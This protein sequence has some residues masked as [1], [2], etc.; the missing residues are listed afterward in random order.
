VRFC[1]AGEDF[2][3]AILERLRIHRLPGA[4][5]R[6]IAAALLLLALAE[7]SRANEKIVIATEGAYPPFNWIDDSGQLR[8]F[9]V[10]IAHALCEQMRSTCE[11][12]TQKWDGILPGLVDKKY[13]AIVASMSNTKERR[14][15]VDF[16]IDYYRDSQSLVA[17]RG[18]NIDVTA[19]SLKDKTIGV[20]GPVLVI[21][22]EERHPVHE[23]YLVDKFDDVEVKIYDS[24]AE[25]VKDLGEGRIDAIFGNCIDLY[26]SVLAPDTGKRFAFAG[27]RLADPEYFVDGA[28]IA[29]RKEDGKLREAFDNALRAIHEN[30]TYRRL[31][32]SYFPAALL[33]DLFTGGAPQ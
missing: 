2:M 8:G 16:T 1:R 15:A 14:K 4:V 25:A 6:L 10:D 11:I 27:R 19:E 5:I 26:L 29:V 28:A 7:N 33:G 24:T 31:Q 32:E 3:R 17:K 20:V 30:G 13:D 18:V 23:R 22:G 9:D 12:V 21:Q